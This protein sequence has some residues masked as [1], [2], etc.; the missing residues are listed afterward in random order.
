VQETI[1]GNS[2][3]SHN[4]PEHQLSFE[5]LFGG[6]DKQATSKNVGKPSSL[7]VQELITALLLP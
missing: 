3:V 2:F 4:P 5:H 6:M 1:P 7:F